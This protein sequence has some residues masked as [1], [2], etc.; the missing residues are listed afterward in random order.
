MQHQE[1]EGFDLYVA[2]SIRGKTICAKQNQ[3][4]LLFHFFP[5]F[6]PMNERTSTL[7]LPTLLYNLIDVAGY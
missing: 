5:T 6:L 7:S 2:D 4:Q 3:N 1:F